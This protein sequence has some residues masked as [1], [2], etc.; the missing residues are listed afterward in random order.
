MG[1]DQLLH[2]HTSTTTTISQNNNN[3]NYLSPVLR[4]LLTLYLT[5]C[6]SQTSLCDAVL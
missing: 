1:Q 6:H 5:P 3:N 4:I 2:A